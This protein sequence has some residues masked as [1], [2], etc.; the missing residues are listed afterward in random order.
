MLDASQ[1]CVALGGGL[2]SGVLVLVVV[3]AVLPLVSVGGC[4]TV[5]GRGGS[6]I[7]NWVSWLR[8]GRLGMYGKSWSEAPVERLTELYSSSSVV[9]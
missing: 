3:L 6:G 5:R 9:D 2:G 1:A 4:L 7:G 8:C